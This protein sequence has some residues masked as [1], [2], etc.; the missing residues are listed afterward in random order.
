MLGVQIFPGA[1]LF[2]GVSLLRDFMNT[3]VFRPREISRLEFIALTAAMMALNALAIDV[4]LPALP[5]IGDAFGLA[6]ENDRPLVLSFYL[7]GVGLA[8]LVFGP[9]TDRFGRRGPLMAGLVIYVV[10]ALG[11]IFAPA[12]VWLLLFRF[13][14]GLG[15]ASFRVITLAV[16]R[17]KF[18]GRVMAEIMSLTFMVFMIVPIVAPGI[19]QLLLFV[20]PWQGIF[21]FVALFGLCVGA[22]AYFRLPETLDPA[23]RRPLSFAGI[24]GGFKI[25]VTH[26]F[27][28]LYS[29]A[30]MLVFGALMG[31][32][33][34][35]Q[36][37]FVDIYGLG[38]RFPLAF[39]GMATTMAVASFV[40]S[41]IVSRFGMRRI[42]HFALIIFASSSGLLLVLSLFGPVPFA[43]FFFL[44]ATALFMFAWSSANMNALAMQPLGAVAGTAAAIFG[45]IQTLGG[46]LIGLV[47]GRM[48]N[49][50][51][52]PIAA[53][54]AVVGVI[55]LL[56]VLWAENGRLFGVGDD[57][58]RA[59][60]R[61]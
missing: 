56:A 44:L 41:R 57:E 54:F 21:L 52:T 33:N 3:P 5:N 18:E 34:S 7:L 55:A 8:Q 9:L 10:T 19:G 45:F 58:T 17:D 48:F 15:A 30:G 23:N 25:V 22:W 53:G 2:P 29:L 61:G 39:A 16:V 35:S 14:Q 24:F 51:I 47:I 32:I 50:T 43:V 12:F 26:R 40:N 27:S 31:M 4:M 49:A 37:I 6:N 38:T 42:A 1:V 20:G 60:V 28:L 46:T 11:A 36:Q 13:V 59:P